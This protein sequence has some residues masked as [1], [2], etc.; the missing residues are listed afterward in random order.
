MLIAPRPSKESADKFLVALRSQYAVACCHIHEYYNAKLAL[1]AIPTADRTIRILKQLAVV[2]ERLDETRSAIECYTQILSQSPHAIEAAIT[3]LQYGTPLTELEVLIA[4]AAVNMRQLIK[5][6]YLSQRC[7]FDSAIREFG[8]LEATFKNNIDLLLAIASCNLKAG[9]TVAAQFQYLRIR[10]LDA[11]C[12]DQVDEYAGLIKS[13]GNIAAL[14]KL[15]EEVF[16]VSEERPEPWLCMARYCEA[17]GDLD[18]ALF[19]TEKAILID[20][21]HVGAYHLKGFLMLA[22]KKPTDAILAFRNSYR[23]SRDIF[24]YEGTSTTY[25]RAFTKLLIVDYKH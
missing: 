4:P 16:R 2:Y 21:R 11:E 25:Y 17:K 24:T 19:Y 18:Q 9:N 12:L 14:N 3:L 1:E 22:Q 13:Q 23:L 7:D 5:A 20:N 10:K 6:H 8:L 15:T